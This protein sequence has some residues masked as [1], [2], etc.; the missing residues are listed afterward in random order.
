MKE[1]SMLERF[2]DQVI[3]RSW[4][5]LFF[6]LFCYAGYH[7][8]IKSKKEEIVSVRN[9][10]NRYKSDKASLC[11]ENEDLQTRLQSQSD[12]EWIQVVLMKEL[13]VVP[14]GQMKILF[15]NDKPDQ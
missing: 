10:L 15:T 13:G 5:V 1:D 14:E 4:W 8:I 2:I 12:P 7:N 11:E 9:K 6:I 3:F